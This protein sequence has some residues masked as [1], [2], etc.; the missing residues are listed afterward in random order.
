MPHPPPVPSLDDSLSS[1]PSPGNLSVEVQTPPRDI[2]RREGPRPGPTLCPKDLEKRLSDVQEIDRLSKN[3]GSFELGPSSQQ[4]IGGPT[5][6]TVTEGGT[7]DSLP[8]SDLASRS[9]SSMEIDGGSSAEDVFGPVHHTS[10]HGE[11]TSVSLG[12]VSYGGSEG[13]IADWEGSTSPAGDTKLGTHAIEQQQPTPD[14]QHTEDLIEPIDAAG[15]EEPTS[16]D[17]IQEA[18]R[19]IGWMP[20]WA[21]ARNGRAT[22][23]SGYRKYIAIANAPDRPSCALQLDASTR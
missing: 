17:A 9:D 1:N 6:T 20:T 15:I 19:R 12:S 13:L 16:N 18:L 3:L 7:G 10:P 8:A 2:W 5:L 11:P 23:V 22:V 21:D 4:D 14:R